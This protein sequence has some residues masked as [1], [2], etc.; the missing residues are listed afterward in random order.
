MRVAGHEVAVRVMGPADGPVVI[1]AHSSGLGSVQWHGY[2]RALSDR[3]WCCV[4]PDLIGYGASEAWR[5]E[6]PFDPMFDV[7]VLQA[8]RRQF[9][10]REITLLGHSYGAFLSLRAASLWGENL[11][12][13]VL[14]EPVAWGILSEREPEVAVPFWARMRARGF[15]DDEIGGTEA[16]MEGFV[17]Y[18]GG[19]GAWKGLSERGRARMMK[20]GRKTFEEVRALCLDETPGAAY[21]GVTAPVDL[22]CGQRSPVQSRKVCEGLAAVLPEVSLHWIEAGH[23]GPVDAP[24]VVAPMMLR[25]F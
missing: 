5:E 11:R 16:W 3:G 17:D 15:F 14:Y 9:V 24:D 19:V 6:V 8:L 22:F 1:M 12:R 7:E 18:W 20:A 13:L 25:S 2:M 10:G 4:A 21:Q 23:M